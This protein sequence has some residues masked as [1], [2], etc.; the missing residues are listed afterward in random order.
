MSKINTL[1]IYPMGGR[2]IPSNSDTESVQ[3]S[4]GQWII[5]TAFV[6]EGTRVKVHDSCDCS[7][8][9]YTVGKTCARLGGESTDY[10]FNGICSG[11]GKY[12]RSIGPNDTKPS[13]YN[14][15][16]HERFGLWGKNG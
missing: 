13:W 15:V 5:A 2:I 10:H 3:L 11:C 12:A 8:Y 6:R 14:W 1:F 4:N 9:D 16:A 7:S